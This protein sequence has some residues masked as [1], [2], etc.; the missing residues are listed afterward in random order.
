MDESQITSLLKSVLNSTTYTSTVI[1]LH[2]DEAQTFLD[3]IHEVSIL[4]LYK[5]LILRIISYRSSI[6]AYC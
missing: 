1:Q 4:I 5:N 2:G 6:E 3:L